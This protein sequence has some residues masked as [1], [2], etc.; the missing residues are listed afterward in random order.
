L[1]A[2]RSR[3]IADASIPFVARDDLMIELAS[4]LT[5]P[6]AKLLLKSW[7]GESVAVDI[8]D[9]LLKLGFSR[10]GDWTKARAAEHRANQIAGA[11][12]KDLEDIFTNERVKEAEIFPAEV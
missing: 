3:G 7:L 12:V 11:V 10:F 8:G 5:L 9:N 6:I 2:N 1:A 4:A